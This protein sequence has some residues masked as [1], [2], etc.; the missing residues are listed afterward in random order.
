M[1]NS[2]IH[3]YQHQIFDN[4][5]ILPSKMFYLM[6]IATSPKYYQAKRNPEFSWFKNTINTRFFSKWQIL[7]NFSKVGA[8]SPGSMTYNLASQ[9]SVLLGMHWQSFI[10]VRLCDLS[11]RFKIKI[12]FKM[13]I[14]IHFNCLNFKK[15]FF[16]FWNW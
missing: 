14:N 11:W 1:S 5:K 9:I 3:L 12:K 8:H 10:E 7:I 13:K 2:I 4:C 16:W 15:G 6:K